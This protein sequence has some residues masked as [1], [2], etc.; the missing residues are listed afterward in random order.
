MKDFGEKKVCEMG[1]HYYPS[2]SPECPECTKSKKLSSGVGALYAFDDE[3]EITIGYAFVQQGFNP[4]VGWLVCVEG[5]MRGQDYRFYD[6]NN[7]IGR[8][9][10]MDI[11]L[12]KDESITRIRHA[13]ISYDSRSAKYYYTP[14]TSRNIDALNDMPIFSSVEL[15]SGD[16]LEI[17]GSKLI[18]VALCSEEFK[19]EDWNRDDEKGESEQ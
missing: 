5:P 1:H 9:R 17:G 3:D 12:Q 16:M 8:D 18:F 14:G 4:L 11:C 15:K 7:F 19:W 13:T 10:S 2:L 6:G